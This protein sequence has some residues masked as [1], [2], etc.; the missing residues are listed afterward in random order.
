MTVPSNPNDPCPCN[1]GL[2][3][4][5]CHQP[6]V[7][8]S[9]EDLLAVG[10]REYARRWEGNTTFYEEQGLYQ[11]LAEHLAGAG[12][13][14]RIVDVGC[15]RG[16]GIAALRAL[17]NGSHFFGVFLNLCGSLAVRH[18]AAIGGY[19]NENEIVARPGGKSSGCCA[20]R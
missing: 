18:D 2:L 4:G 7:E 9:D 10:H 12:Q 6:V 16:Q 15:G 19:A 1:S 3:Y 17:A 5:E 8:A 11:S 13:I 14:E 20:H